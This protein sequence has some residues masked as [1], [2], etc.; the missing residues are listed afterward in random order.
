LVYG[1][2]C[3]ILSG[4]VLAYTAFFLV[5]KRLPAERSSADLISVAADLAL[6]ALFGAQHSVMARAGFKNWW[7]KVIPASVDRSTYLLCSSGVLF[8]VCFLWQ[9]VPGRVWSISNSVAGAVVLSIAGAGLAII[10]I[11]SIQLDHLE[12]AGLRQVWADFRGRK[13]HEI[14]FRT[15]GLYRIVRHPLTLGGLMVLWATPAMTYDRFLFALGMTIYALLGLVLEERDLV[16][17]FGKEY[18]H[19]RQR[20]PMLLPWKGKAI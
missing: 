12:L 9:S 10:A 6:I 19:Y 18:E 13:V 7:T 16:R 3:Y 2:A 5:R 20:V 8:A 1:I 15:P 17:R 14:P 4:A 11:A